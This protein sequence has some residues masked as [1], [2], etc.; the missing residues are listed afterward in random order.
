[1]PDFLKN[2]PPWFLVLCAL[3]GFFMFMRSLNKLDGTLNRFEELF[4]KNFEKHEDH[5]SRISKLEGKLEGKR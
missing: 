2:L 1:M 3:A 4:D 5:E